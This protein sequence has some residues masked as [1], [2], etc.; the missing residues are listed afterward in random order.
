MGAEGTAVATSELG[1]DTAEAVAVAEGPDRTGAEVVE[2]SDALRVKVSPLDSPS[3][4]RVVPSRSSGSCQSTH[5]FTR[6]KQGNALTSYSP[7]LACYM[8]ACNSVRSPNGH[9]DSQFRIHNNVACICT[10]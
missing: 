9:M 4:A 6:N 10:V 1:P 8:Y 3:S 7:C 2:A 5:M